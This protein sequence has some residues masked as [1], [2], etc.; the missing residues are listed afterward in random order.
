MSVGGE[1][2]VSGSVP[3]TDPPAEPDETPA[4]E[5]TLGGEVGAELLPERGPLRTFL[6]TVGVIEQAVGTSL[7][8]VILVLVLV[9]VA[10]RY[11]PSFAGWPGTGEIAR[12][13]LVWCTVILSGYLLAQDRHITIRA[14][15][16]VVSG[17]A[18]DALKLMVHVVVAVTCIAMAYATYRLIADDIGQRTPEANLPLAWVYLVP[19]VGFV[20]TALRAGLAIGL[21]DVPGLAGRR[22]SP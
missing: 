18:L 15:D 3:P 12:L 14:I 9:Q 11:L 20:L 19:F 2:P 21:V 8:F 13:S 6:K 10:G 17:R 5:P 16:F 7:I 4:A 1:Q 22:K